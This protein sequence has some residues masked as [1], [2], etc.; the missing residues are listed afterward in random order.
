MPD[1]LGEKTEE[2]TEKKRQE[3][4]NK[5]QVAR[6]T[7]LTA[8]ALMLFVMIYLVVFSGNIA[9]QMAGAMRG[10][11]EIPSLS[12]AVSPGALFGLS[13]FTFERLVGA[14]LPFMMFIFAV[15]AASQY[16][17]V[18]W[19]VTLKP[20]QPKLSNLNP[21]KGLKRTFSKK[22]AMKSVLDIG[23]VT[24][25]LSVGLVH[26]LLSTDRIATLPMLSTWRS[27]LEATHI[28]L[29]GAIW[30]LIILLLIGIADIV[31]QRW[32][33]NQEL[34]MTKHEVKE[35]RKSSEGDPHVKSRRF[36]LMQELL[37]Q[38]I[39]SAVPK[40]DVVVTNPT[41]FSVALQYDAEKM[42]A[43]RVIA[44]GADHLALRIRM[45][46]TSSGVPIVERPPLARA[47]YYSVEPGEQIP[48]EHYEAVA[49]L[50][51]YVYRLDQK[52]AS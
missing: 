7:D 23:K 11:L 2:P 46:A 51:A 43:P 25:V 47:L 29:E 48:M 32:N 4:R 30:V 28:I 6:S 34:R 50:L 19:R 35:E 26:L 5:G 39:N 18:G 52:A 33:H 21:Q 3:A 42:P 8:A 27:V 20:I 10:A 16:L 41:H 13:G 12:D 22:N 17:Q 38:Q 1:D 14:A 24:L 45:V 37:S 40:A 9:R 15:A 49:E 44:K 31:F 36:R